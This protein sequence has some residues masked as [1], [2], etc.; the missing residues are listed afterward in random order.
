MYFAVGMHFKRSCCNSWVNISVRHKQPY[1]LNAK[2]AEEVLNSS[3]LWL[4]KINKYL[5]WYLPYLWWIVLIPGCF[6]CIF[7]STEGPSAGNWNVVQV[8]SCCWDSLPGSATR[9]CLDYVSS[10]SSRARFPLHYTLGTGVV[11]NGI[12]NELICM[13][14]DRDDFLSALNFVAGCKTHSQNENRL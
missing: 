10:S 6:A 13:G 1:W 11:A 8:V 3:L 4:R 2:I 9:N 14:L 7:L 5:W 12:V